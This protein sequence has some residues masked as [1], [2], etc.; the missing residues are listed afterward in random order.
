MVQIHSMIVIE[1]LSIN[2]G[3]YTIEN[4]N[5]SR[6]VFS[7]NTKVS[8]LRLSLIA[9]YMLDLVLKPEILLRRYEKE[10]LVCSLMNPTLG[11]HSSFVLIAG[12]S[13]GIRKLFIIKTRKNRTKIS[14]IP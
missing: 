5:T 11:K 8:T 4:R 3:L 14:T 2:A 13:C 10:S 12:I 7:H 6:P 1:S 9:N